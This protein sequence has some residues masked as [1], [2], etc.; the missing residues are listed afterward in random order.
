MRRVV[1]VTVS[2]LVLA[3]LFVAAGCGGDGA[4]GSSPQASSAPSPVDASEVLAAATVA[5]SEPGLSLSMTG[6]GEME[7]ALADR[8]TTIAMRLDGVAMTPSK[9]RA[10]YTLSAGGATQELE[11]VSLDG[12]V[13]WI[14]E[15]G[16]ETWSKSPEDQ[17][18]MNVGQSYAAYA[19]A[20]T[21]T[22]YV[23]SASLGGVSCSIIEIEYDPAVYA[24]ADP[25]GSS[26][27]L[28]AEFLQLTAAEV[29]AA[30]ESGKASARL[31][32]GADGRV[33]REV[34]EETL[35]AGAK[36]TF[37]EHTESTYSHYGEPIDP[38]IVKP[39][40]I[41]PAGSSGV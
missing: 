12:R 34:E 6:T 36:G 41:V 18:V 25:A 16:S 40:P 30:L 3:A 1:L 33:Y 9:L 17:N 37:V 38:P 4:A 39:S 20:A 15:A 35:D 29:Q 10:T 24:K 5:M 28:A 2:L 32:V 23:G 14:R 7:I 8:N 19:Q 13:A 31:W 27:S 22:T 21:S 26:G 11:I